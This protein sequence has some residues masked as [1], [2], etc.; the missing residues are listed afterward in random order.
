M[1]GG[2]RLRV[3]ATDFVLLPAHSQLP[4]DPLSAAHLV[5][6]MLAEPIARE[7]LAQELG[8]DADHLDAPDIRARAIAMIA[9]GELR[10]FDVTERRSIGRPVVPQSHDPILPPKR[11]DP[12]P[13][14]RTWIA[15]TVVDANGRGFADT[16]WI[17]T[18]PDGDDHEIRLDAA[19]TWRADDL[20]ASGTC[21]LRMG[22]AA[23]QATDARTTVLI[24]P[25]LPRIVRAPRASVALRTGVA[26]TVVVEERRVELMRVALGA[27]GFQQQSVLTVPWASLPHLNPWAAITVLATYMRDHPGATY[28]AIGHH[29]VEEPSSHSRV[30]AEALVCFIEGDRATWVAAA[31]KWGNL[32]NVFEWLAYLRSELGWPIPEIDGGAEARADAVR[33][34]Q[35]SYNARTAAEIHEDGIVGV[36]TLG[37]MFDVMREELLAW[38]ELHGADPSMIVSHD[39]A[40]PVLACG[41]AFKPHRTMPER[42]THHRDRFVDLVVIPAGESIDLGAQP[43]GVSIY[44]AASIGTLPLD[45]IAAPKSGL[46]LEIVLRDENDAPVAG[47]AFEVRTPG[48]AIR[49]GT[50]DDRGE[51]RITG[52]MQGCCHVRFPELAPGSWM[53]HAATPV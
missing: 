12:R 31:A 35:Q 5:D 39:F 34:F 24:T 41:Q 14:Q 46:V 20:V 48:G 17:L 18:T 43:T 44:E 6:E 37:A 38:L 42:P 29:E 19:S 45:G 15:I 27:V 28:V 53:L 26:H 23:P 11:D 33:A 40:T 2:T 4:N 32:D 10:A 51:A 22:R 1:S 3:G 47:T 52:V 25:V 30:R 8:V 50:L 36:Q 9:G 13:A 21:H 49:R 7:V 16:S